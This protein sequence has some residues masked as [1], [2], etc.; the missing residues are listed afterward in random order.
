MNEHRSLLKKVLSFCPESQNKFYSAGNENML[1]GCLFEF[2]GISTFVGYLM[3]NPF[4]Y[5]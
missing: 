3:L 1:V 4:L 2:Y 5:K